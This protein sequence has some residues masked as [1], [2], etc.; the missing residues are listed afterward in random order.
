MTVLPMPCLVPPSST[1]AFASKATM[2]SG[3]SKPIFE[4]ACTPSPKGIA[5]PLIAI[6]LPAALALISTL[7]Q[8]VSLIFGF[9][10][11]SLSLVPSAL[12]STGSAQSAQSAWKPS[13]PSVTTR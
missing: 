6:A 10:S 9:R 12:R 7:P 8:P 5:A 4:G 3:R 2:P 1:P 13:P 11:V